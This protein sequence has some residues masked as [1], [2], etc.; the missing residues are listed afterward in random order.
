MITTGFL[1]WELFN[2]LFEYRCGVT[3]LATVAGMHRMHE[4][5]IT[6]IRMR[7][8]EESEITIKINKCTQYQLIRDNRFCEFFL[9]LKG[10]SKL[11][12]NFVHVMMSCKAGVL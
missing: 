5:H 7:C 8:L 6:H 3:P 4:P 10:D 2:L 11:S 1:L 12:H 9:S